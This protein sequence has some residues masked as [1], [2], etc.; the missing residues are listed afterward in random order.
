[1]KSQ[2]NGSTPSSNYEGKGSAQPIPIDQL[3][4]TV[5]KS[6]NEWKNALANL[7]STLSTTQAKALCDQS[8]QDCMRGMVVKTKD[9]GQDQ[10][11]T[12]GVRSTSDVGNPSDYISQYPYNRGGPS[13]SNDNDMQKTPF[14]NNTNNNNNNNN[15]NNKGD[16]N[17]LLFAPQK[18]PPPLRP[19]SRPPRSVND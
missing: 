14:N 7:I 2:T 11:N 16:N 19:P 18:G 1:M 5:Q 6:M 9:L 3:S 12:I 8:L 15:D 4:E 13:F 17:G 10:S